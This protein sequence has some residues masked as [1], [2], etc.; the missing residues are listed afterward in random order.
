VGDAV[1]RPRHAD[2]GYT[3]EP[4]RSRRVPELQWRLRHLC[5]VVVVAILYNSGDAKLERHHVERGREPD[6]SRAVNHG[7]EIYDRMALPLESSDGAEPQARGR[8]YGHLRR[9]TSDAGAEERQ[10]LV[11]SLIASDSSACRNTI[12]VLVTG[13]ENDGPSAYLAANGIVAEASSFSSINGRRV[14]IYVV[15][16]EPAGRR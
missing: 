4:Q 5:P 3:L 14:P 10:E 16:R 7:G 13:G 1:R 12:V 9:P 8:R 6:L 2:G 15:W 11:S